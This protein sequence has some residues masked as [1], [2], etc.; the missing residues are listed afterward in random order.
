MNFKKIAG[1]F[2]T[3]EGGEGVGKT[4]Q[5]KLFVD[6]L[7]EN[8]IKAVWTREPGGCEEAEEIRKLV[9]SGDTGRWDGITELL[10]M[11]AARRVHTEK[12]IKP[13]LRENITVVSDRYVDSSLAY[14]GFGHNLPIKKLETIQ[15]LVL[16]DF[17]PD[18]TL[19]L[20]MNLEDSLARANVRGDTN[21]F[22]TMTLNFHRRVREGFAYAMGKNPHRFIKIAVDNLGIEEVSEKIL[23]AVDDYSWGD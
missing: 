12:K 2:I 1:K 21:R 14:Q 16:D 17:E 22:E 18:L 5:S 4:T 20:D 3:F 13:L 23:A 10:L 11:Y 8:G 6:K 7:N 15:K 9:T 19:L